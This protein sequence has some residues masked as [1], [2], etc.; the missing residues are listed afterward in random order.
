MKRLVVPVCSLAALLACSHCALSQEKTTE[1]AVALRILC[2][3]SPALNTWKNATPETFEGAIRAREIHHEVDEHG[4][5]IRW[6]LAQWVVVHN[7]PHQRDEVGIPGRFDFRATSHLVVFR[8]F[9][10]YGKDG[11]KG[12]KKE[13]VRRTVAHLTAGGPE[14]DDPAIRYGVE[15]EGIK[16]V[17]FAAEAQANQGNAYPISWKGKTIAWIKSGWTARGTRYEADYECFRN[18]EDV[19]AARGGKRIVSRLALGSI[20]L[21][22]GF[23]V[24]RSPDGIEPDLGSPGV[25]PNFIIPPKDEV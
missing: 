2:V 6:G 25:R 5:G 3:D 18:Q 12:L 14:E 21:S 17:P 11:K 7:P 8:E 9:W 16:S 4:E 23:V 1:A 15:H 10:T 22:W 24:R 13:W 19:V 20:Y